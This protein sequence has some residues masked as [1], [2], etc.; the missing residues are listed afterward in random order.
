[1]PNRLPRCEKRIR[2]MRGQGGAG[3]G[4]KKKH[5]GKGSRGGKGWAGSTKHRRS[6]VYKYAPDHFGY[7][8]FRP[9]QPKENVAI[10]LDGVEKLASGK[11]E[12]NLTELGYTK[13]LSRG[14][15]SKPLTITVARASAGAIE[16]V[17]AAKGK[18]ILE[19]VSEED[20]KAK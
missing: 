19:E 7:K 9:P 5:R 14:K 17:K 16:A 8:G 6:Y 11:S 10:N 4:G 3:Y 1:M 12:I 2:Q 15:L 20:E 18:L 13:L